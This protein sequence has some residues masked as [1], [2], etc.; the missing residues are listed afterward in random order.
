MSNKSTIMDVARHAGVAKSTVSFVLNGKKNINTEI[1]KRIFT[2]IKQLE[3]QPSTMAK[4]LKNNRTMQIGVVVDD[5]TNPAAGI[6]VD[7]ISHQLKIHGYHMLLGLAPKEVDQ[8]TVHQYLKNF[9]FGMVDG[10][11]NMSSIVGLAEA[12]S[13]CK[14]VPT[15]TFRRVACNGN[16]HDLIDFASAIF[17]CME[18]LTELGHVKIGILVCDN[19]CPDFSVTPI[20][21]GYREFCAR[22]KLF[23]D[24][25]MIERVGVLDSNAEH[26][27]RLL[28]AGA[29][30]IIAS[31][32]L[33]AANVIQM[34]YKR[35]LK[36]PDDFSLIGLEDTMLTT[37]TT[38]NLTSLQMP[39]D[40]IAELTVRQLLEKINDEEQ[41]PPV[42]VIP[43]LIVRN[44]TGPVPAK[45][46]R[47]NLSSI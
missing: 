39:N 37:L 34:A 28:D 42:A 4:L 12:E 27:A 1:K 45:T 36:I 16:I 21:T 19:Q 17:K 29:T 5:V 44:S 8:Q 10:I 32:D 6:G 15:V 33:M 18:Y 40:A 24:E 35:G 26:G 25:R 46:K 11:I 23:L 3:Y 20:E 31:S 9:S 2:A 43:K 30:A 7:S 22:E 38:P 47:V 14:N 13:L 41:I